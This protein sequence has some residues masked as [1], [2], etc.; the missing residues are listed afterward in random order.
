MLKEYNFLRANSFMKCTRAQIKNKK[1]NDYLIEFDYECATKQAYEI[2]HVIIDMK[3]RDLVMMSYND[4]YRYYN[5]NK[6]P[7]FTFRSMMTQVLRY[8]E[9][10]FRQLAKYSK[11]RAANKNKRSRFFNRSV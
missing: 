9:K 4:K 8:Y 2:H 1:Y 3:T 10:K 7:H 6:L 5:I 11:K